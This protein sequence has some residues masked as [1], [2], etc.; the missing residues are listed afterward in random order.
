MRNAWIRIASLMIGMLLALS[1]TILSAEKSAPAKEGEVCGTIQGLTCDAGLW[2]DLQEGA[3]KGAD[4]G[5]ICVKPE[6]ACTENHAQVCGC[7]GKTYSNDCKRIKA[8]VQKDHAGACEPN[9]NQTRPTG[10]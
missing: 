1:S 2:C 10:K 7:N 3:C 5:G 4:L 8:K 6:K 9:K